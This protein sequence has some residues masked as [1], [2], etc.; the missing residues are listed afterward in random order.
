M[1]RIISIFTV[2]LLFGVPLLTSAAL[3]GIDVGT[4]WTKAAIVQPRALQ[5]VLN[6]NSGRKTHTLVGFDRDEVVYGVDA[7]NFL[8]KSPKTIYS[9]TPQLLGRQYGDPV[10]TSLKDFIFNDLVNHTERGGIYGIPKDDIMFGPEDLMGMILGQMR[11]LGVK[12]PGGSTVKDV[13]ITVPAF[14]T[15]SQ[16][17]ALLDAAKLG[18]ANVL[19]LLHQHT[20]IGIN[21][22]VE[23]DWDENGTNVIFFD[24]GAGSTQVSLVTYKAV[25][26]TR[27]KKPVATGQLQ[28]QAVSWDQTLGGRQFDLRLMNHFVDLIKTSNGP[29]VTES[30]RAMAKLL[31]EAEK[32]KETLSAN[33]ETFAIV[34]GL[35]GDY[36]FKTKV[37]RKQFEELCA[38]LFDRAVVPLRDVL[39]RSNFSIEDVQYVEL[40][41]GGG[42]IPRVQQKLAELLGRDVDKHLNGDEAGVMGAAFY[43]AT[44]SST[45]KVKEFKVKDLHPFAINATVDTGED[46]SEKSVEIFSTRTRLGAKKSL[47]LS[48]SENF[49]LAL[50]YSDENPQLPPGTVRQIGLFNVTGVPSQERYNYTGKPK[51]QLTFRLNQYGMPVVEKAEAEITVLANVTVRDTP[52]AANKTIPPAAKS[53]EAG[54]SAADAGAEGSDAATEAASESETKSDDADADGALGNDEAAAADDSAEQPAPAD[55]DASVDATVANSTAT[56][57]A[58]ATA[59]APAPIKYITKLVKRVQHIALTVSSLAAAGMTSDEFRS[60]Q[61]ILVDIKKRMEDKREKEREKNTLEAYIYEYKDKI[62]GDFFNA[63]TSAEQR[64]AFSEQLSAAATWLEDEG[65]DATAAVYRNKLKDLE[66]VGSKFAQRLSEL[67]ERPKAVGYLMDALNSTRLYVANISET[68]NV[69][70]EEVNSTLVLV[71]DARDWLLRKASEQ[72]SLQPHEDLVFTSDDVVRKWKVI[73]AAVKVLNRKPFNRPKKVEVETVDAANSTTNSSANATAPD[74][75]AASDTEGTAA[76]TA[77]PANVDAD[78]AASSDDQPADEQTEPKK[79]EPLKAKPPTKDDKKDDKKKDAKKDAKPKQD[80]K[81]KADKKGDK[82]P[83][84]KKDAKDKAKLKD[85]KPKANGKSKPE[86]KKPADKKAKPKAGDHDEL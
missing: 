42:R 64:T 19:A 70:E 56:E 9:L 76:D 15:A 31:K 36:D 45:R 54:D 27:S 8:T 38:D 28:V 12:Q 47:T 29:D 23:K 81:K 21:Y 80:D 33:Q 79:P 24:M 1:N 6:D 77:D 2:F 65:F 3:M 66:A 44:L 58:N 84:D 71:D 40:V 7:N 52:P 10:V 61:K 53:A 20:A 37:T 68:R 14:Y 73:D 16:R 72:A 86:S 13:V 85:D 30:P 55:A 63:V 32:A 34:E 83:A 46:D 39:E 22:G 5:I 11:E 67:E 60:S 4:K 57:A 62:D 41:G 50:S 48:T 59:E 18:G 49:T 78:A 69:T 82:K 75:D 43:S 26:D 51:I 25:N 35:L 74:V 17:Q